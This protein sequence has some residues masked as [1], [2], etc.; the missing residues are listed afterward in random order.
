LVGLNAQVEAVDVFALVGTIDAVQASVSAPR[1]E[2]S[3]KDQV[4]EKYLHR[5]MQIETIVAQGAICLRV[6][7]P[8]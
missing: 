3:D 2:A 4:I 7:S 5:G 6:T 1:S 8:S